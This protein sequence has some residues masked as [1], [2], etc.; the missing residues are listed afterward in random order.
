MIRWSSKHSPH[1]AGDPELHHVSGT[2]LASSG[3]A[4]DAERHLLLGT[5]DSPSV[6]ANLEFSW[7]T[8]DSPDTAPLY[9]ARC[10]LPYLLVGNIRAATQAHLLFTSKLPPTLAFE[11]VSSENGKV[12]ARVYPSLPLLNFLTLLLVA[13]QRGAGGR[14]AFS[15]LRSKYRAYLEEQAGGT[16]DEALE[17]V[18]ESWFGVRRPR[19]QGNPLMDMMGSMF[20]GGGGGGSGRSQGARAPPAVGVD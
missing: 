9:C 5:R 20:A 17:M 2:L 4:Y 1:P 3:D 16:W 13:V 11:N 8:Q 7:Y 18:G 10:V 14:Q 6:L 19:P 15:Q 12:D